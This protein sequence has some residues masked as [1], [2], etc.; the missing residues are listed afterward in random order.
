[1]KRALSLPNVADPRVL[2][3][4][5]V[6]AEANGWDGVFLWDHLLHEGMPDHEVVDPWVVLGAIAQATE[7]ITI[8]T[9][10]TPL[11]R[12][13]PQK[14][15][16]E[17]ATLDALS[18]GRAVLGV[19]LGVPLDFEA[20]GEPVDPRSRAALL[21]AALDQIDALLGDRR[22]PVWVAGQW[23]NPGPFRRAARWDGVVPLLQAED[24]SITLCRPD[25][26]RAIRAALGD[27]PAGFDVVTSQHWEH[28]PQE[29]EDAGVTWLLASWDAEPEWVRE[30]GAVAARPPA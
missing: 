21:D 29:L 22:P 12:R 26:I 2:V 14:V 1:M 19:G 11:A 5:A 20:F 8:G 23:P 15:A 25:D 24:G 18:G 13:R 28:T 7:R 9:L 30:L 16:R 6:T 10:I 3:D 4:I 17:I 27:V